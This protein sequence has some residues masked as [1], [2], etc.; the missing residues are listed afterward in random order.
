ME[1]GNI[2]SNTGIC[3]DPGSDDVGSD[4]L[5]Q[6]FCHV[7]FIIL[8]GTVDRYAYSAG[9]ATP[10]CLLLG[11]LDGVLCLSLA[12]RSAQCQC[13]L[14]YLRLLGRIRLC[15]PARMLAG[16]AR[17]VSTDFGMLSLDM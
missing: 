8:G 5:L 13:V 6:P 15:I 17:L 14:S 4:G 1:K 12:A 16:F 11:A 7:S 9:P 10:E 3:K 2:V